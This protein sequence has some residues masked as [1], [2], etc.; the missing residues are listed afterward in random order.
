[1]T[2]TINFS[3]SPSQCP[4][5]H[6]AWSAR[7]LPCRTCGYLAPSPLSVGMAGLSAG[8]SGYVGPHADFYNYVWIENGRRMAAGSSGVGWASA[9]IDLGPAEKSTPVR[10]RAVRP[11]TT[12]FKGVSSYSARERSRVSAD[13]RDFRAIIARYRER[14][15]RILTDR[16]FFAQQAADKAAA[17]LAEQEALASM[18]K[19]EAAW[20]AALIA[21]HRA[22]PL[23]PSPRRRASGV[24][25]RTR[26]QRVREAYKPLYRYE[27][28]TYEA[29]PL[30][31]AD[32]PP[33]VTFSCSPDM[34]SDFKPAV[35]WT[36]L[37][38]V[39][40]PKCSPQAL[41][42]FWKIW[43]VAVFWPI[44][45]VIFAVVGI[46]VLSRRPSPPSLYKPRRESRASRAHRSRHGL[47]LKNIPGFC[48]LRLFQRSDQHQASIVLGA[49]PPAY[50]LPHLPSSLKL[51][52]NR[53]NA[54]N[55]G[56]SF[57]HIV[58]DGNQGIE[59]SLLVR[60]ASSFGSRRLG[61]LPPTLSSQGEPQGRDRSQETKIAGEYVGRQVPGLNNAAIVPNEYLFSAST[62]DSDSR[63]GADSV[64]QELAIERV[65][66]VV[67]NALI[68]ASTG[69]ISAISCGRT[70]HFF[71]HFP[72]GS[73]RMVS[74]FTSS[75]PIFPIVRRIHGED[76]SAVYQHRSP[77]DK[78]ADIPFIGSALETHPLAAMFETTM[79]ISKIDSCE[80]FLSSRRFAG[81][82]GN[83]QILAYESSMLTRAHRWRRLGN[84]DR[85]GQRYYTFMFN[86]WCMYFNRQIEDVL[87]NTIAGQAG[88]WS[89]ARAAR[90]DNPLPANTPATALNGEHIPSHLSINPLTAY[91][92]PTAMN[93]A[94]DPEDS[95]WIND[96]E[97]IDAIEA[98]EAVF[99]D[100]EGLSDRALGLAVRAFA[101]MTDRLYR[102]WAPASHNTRA[103]TPPLVGVSV[104]DWLTTKVGSLNFYIHWGPS[105]LPLGVAMGN[106]SVATFGADFTGN[107]V[108]PD[109]TKCPWN[110]NYTRGEIAALMRHFC[111]KHHA[112]A[113]CWAAFD[114]AIY[115]T[116][117][118]SLNLSPN[119]SP[120]ADETVYCDASLNHR[121]N[122]PANLTMP[123]YLDWAR[124]PAPS[125]G[126]GEDLEAIWNLTPTQSYWMSQLACQAHASSVNWAAS[127]FS[128]F[129]TTIA[130]HM[131]N[132]PANDYERNHLSGMFFK[133]IEQT[134]NPWLTRHAA[135]T[136]VMY[137]F[138]PTDSTL[139]TYGQKLIN[140]WD[141]NK[142]P[143]LL[144]AYHDLWAV[145]VLPASYKLPCPDDA[146]EWNEQEA[147]PV[148]GQ[149]Q[150]DEVRV[151]R[152]T[153]PFTGRAYVQDGGQIMNLQYYM[154][155]G[156]SS[157]GFRFEA[158]AANSAT[159]DVHAAVQ[160]CAWDTPFRHRHPRNVDAFS[161][162]SLGPIGTPW[163]DFITPGSIETF[164]LRSNR[165]RALGCRLGAVHVTGALR[166]HV[167]RQWFLMSSG[168]TPSR[169]LSVTYEHPLGYRYDKEPVH[170]Y[171]M[172]IYTTAQ[173]DYDRVSFHQ[174]AP[175][176][177]SLSPAG[178]NL[179]PYYRTP[180][181]SSGLP[182]HL[183]NHDPPPAGAPPVHTVNMAA[184]APRPAPAPGFFA[185]AAPA[186][187]R[188]G[189]MMARLAAE[190]Q[191][192]EQQAQLAAQARS[193]A[194]HNSEQLRQEA[195]ILSQIPAVPAPTPTPAPRPPPVRTP[196]APRSTSPKPGPSQAELLE[197][198]RVVEAA[199]AARDALN[200]RGGPE[201]RPPPPRAQSAQPSANYESKNPYS[202]TQL[203]KSAP[204]QG[205]LFV[206][207]AGNF[208][209][210][211]PSQGGYKEFEFSSLTAESFDSVEASDAAAPQ[212][213]TPFVAAAASAPPR[214]D[215]T[216]AEREA[217][218]ST[219]GFVPNSVPNP[220]MAYSDA[221][222]F[223]ALHTRAEQAD[224]TSGT[225]V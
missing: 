139:E 172:L 165:V 187:V 126:S 46:P 42:A 215:L 218:N 80:R 77:L 9:N 24:R 181:H 103:L 168:S 150:S 53:L 23:P 16:A 114:A 58:S 161:P 109:N 153:L 40:F 208:F 205:K 152:N 142:S 14:G 3:V 192:A 41:I 90:A 166:E 212:A 147:R 32:E 97:A 35:N 145:K 81:I 91:N 96:G 86:L 107:G 2:S 43:F 222:H 71:R 146:P 121:I 186:Q 88:A 190:R 83:R 72:E 164:K 177:S 132:N 216:S 100:R 20:A 158:T 110:I 191:Y 111:V 65:V 141:D 115:R 179:D 195:E 70:S 54:M 38:A 62:V 118:F 51:T 219:S 27:W 116:H 30:F 135:A 99:I 213:Q 155:T 183:A 66:P 67:Q 87:G 211:P 31:K 159:H 28:P 17:A 6:S 176:Q 113:D 104:A 45:F 174:N 75:A 13:R 154:A 74:R 193:R 94:N 178:G 144:N 39:R 130:H 175:L 127:C 225:T 123:A 108:A 93:T 106:W 202:A 15:E 7:A 169:N 224:F 49:F 50:L 5:L 89:Q 55:Y 57:S 160:A 171:S 207:V 203:P 101:P 19:V 214:P 140:A 10:P 182:A 173:G 12:F 47:S 8:S 122:L 204:V 189:P 112:W 33:L 220:A 78:M 26:S 120:Q 162:T 85:K 60:Y 133:I 148:F 221:Q 201:S 206:D 79:D 125:V 44:L 98:G 22:T 217:I 63:I 188:P 18:K 163:A 198:Q 34:A 151:S 21:Q 1:M 134:L 102:Q 37:G 73:G 156:A 194:V 137:G 76:Y 84:A 199:T 131:T 29:G 95:L 209:S 143:F 210:S 124:A 82:R 136:K 167:T 68:G 56:P 185:R 64:P 4:R 196:R 180:V 119:V 197:A 36:A 48:H 69:Q 223:Q 184:R 61:A 117:Q 59:A 105:N 25:Q 129:G 92:A 157:G 170:D 149:D 128:L 138:R 52:T 200:A 11:P